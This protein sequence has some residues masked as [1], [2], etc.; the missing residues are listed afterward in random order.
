[1]TITIPNDFYR[2]ALENDVVYGIN[3]N[4]VVLLNRKNDS[5]KTKINLTQHLIAFGIEGEKY[6]HTNLL[7]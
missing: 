6:F 7:D 1:M 4:T 5:N 3:E 2:S